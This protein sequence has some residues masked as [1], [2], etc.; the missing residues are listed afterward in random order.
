[1][2]CPWSVIPSYSVEHRNNSVT[3]KKDIAAIN[4]E[5]HRHIAMWCW[6]VATLEVF[7]NEWNPDHVAFD[8][9][10][11]YDECLAGIGPA[12]L[13]LTALERLVRQPSAG[14]CLI[15]ISTLLSRNV[16]KSI[17][18]VLVDLFFPN[19]L[20]ILVSML[21]TL[22]FLCIV[23]GALL[24]DLLGLDLENI[25]VLAEHVSLWVHA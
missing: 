8:I 13:L 2:V 3:L 15:S 11:A 22:V 4:A 20:N 17:A 12:A 9:R 18:N 24:V 1:M 23:G 21:F 10:E 19:V 14:L 16:T 7:T 25:L 6:H 5:Y